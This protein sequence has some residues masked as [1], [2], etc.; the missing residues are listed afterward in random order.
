MLEHDEIL[1][2]HDKAYQANQGTREQAASDLVF[3]WV[4][5]WDDNALSESQLTFRGEFDNLRKAGRAILS[6]LSSNPVQVDFETLDEDSNENGDLADGLYRR[7]AKNNLSKEA[8]KNADQ[9]SVVCGMGAWVLYTDY[10][11]NRV[12]DS[13]QVIKRRPI[14]EANS[15][16]FFDPSAKLLD[17][18]DAD[19]CSIIWTYS[20]DGFKKTVADITGEEIEEV[21]IVDFKTPEQSFAFP[22]AS[23]GEKHYIGEFYHRELITD[24][25]LTLNDLLGDQVIL[26][27]SELTD[28]MDELISLGYSVVSEKEIRRYQVT[29]YVVTGTD[30]IEKTVIAGEHIPVVPEYGEHAYV[31]GEEHYEGVTRLAKDPQRLRDFQL[32]YLADIV[33]QSPRT[34]PIFFPE[35][36]AGYENMY[37]IT[38]ADN[39][40]PYLLQNRT[41]VN[42]AALPIGPVAQLPETP[43]PPALVASI[44]L[45]RE[46]IEDVANPG[47]PQN[48]S[49]PDISGKA[50]LALQASIDKQ[51][52]IYQDNRKHALRRDGEVW[53]SMAK[54]V[55]D[56]PRRETIEGPDGSTRTVEVMKQVV[57]NQTGKVV[58][59]NDLRST[60]F[61]VTSEIGPSYSSKKEQTIE[62]LNSI[63]KDIPP[64][65]PLR[66]LMIMKVLLLMD[67]TDF[68]EIREYAVKQLIVKGH[69]KPENEEENQWLM[70]A[71]QEGGQPSAEMLIGM[72]EMK[73]ATVEEGKLQLQKSKLMADY[74]NNRLKERVNAFKAQSERM[75]VQVSAQEAGATIKNKNIDSFGKQID[76]QIKLSKINQMEN[77]DIFKVLLTG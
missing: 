65:D 54:V 8:F 69:R 42:G 12:G 13:R 61:E 37:S 22:W 38:G 62:R 74:E 10:M 76:N 66:E 49:D 71:Q 16:V 11:T 77:E 52:L 25:V 24:T 18:S 23:E 20:P 46:A 3:Y 58:T 2:L 56:T 51:S 28:V 48:L 14:F 36:V 32:S 72:A 39:N 35:Q 15:C 41:D 6:D 7:G 29:K 1:K 19:Y 26:Y 50:V 64:G 60:D 34:K 9:E 47:T 40:Y 21:E 5:H 59:L 67:G 73:K 70:E 63:I 43:L 45:S 53:L 68:D 57:D 44:Q 17:K 31:E 27:E 55:Y 75:K 33:S 4:T 30:V